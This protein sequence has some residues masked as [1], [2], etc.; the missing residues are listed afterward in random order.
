MAHERHV[1]VPGVSPQDAVAIE[2][3]EQ[4]KIPL[5]VKCPKCGKIYVL[6]I[7]SFDQGSHCLLGQSCPYCK[8]F[9]KETD[10]PEEIMLDVKELKADIEA[11][12]KEATK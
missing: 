6:F 2:A 1:I 5:R 11:A 3:A 10:D 4:E 7:K 9:L 8:R 12:E